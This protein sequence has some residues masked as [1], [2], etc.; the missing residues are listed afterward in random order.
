MIDKVGNIMY[1]KLRVTSAVQAGKDGRCRSGG[2][3]IK[4]GNYKEADKLHIRQEQPDDHDLVYQ[5]IKKAFEQAEHSDGG[6][7]D[8]VTALRKSSSFIPELSL[9]A[10]DGT[11]IAGHILFTKAFINQT[12]VLALAPLSVLPEYQNR[13]IG[14]SLIKRGHTIAYTLGYGYSIVLGNPKY[15]SR[16][17]YVPASRYGISAP[18]ETEDENFMAVRLGECSE[19]PHGVIAYDPAFG[20]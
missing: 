16:A 8:L 15:Y 13:G 2:A 18:F 10:V 20:I 7:Q 14:L 3:D 19:P 6:E 5:V 1:K 11:R 4:N 17:G 12:E 9:V